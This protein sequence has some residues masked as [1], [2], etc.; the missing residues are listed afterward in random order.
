MG[1]IRDAARRL[2]QLAVPLRQ[3]VLPQLRLLREEKVQLEIYMAPYR[4]KV[5]RQTA[6]FFAVWLLTA[7][8][9]A[10]LGWALRW[11]S[12]IRVGVAFLTFLALAGVFESLWYLLLYKQWRFIVTD[13][14]IIIVTPDPK[15]RGFADAIYLK[16]GKIQVVDTN[17]SHNPWWGL[18]QAATGARDVVLSLA[19]YEFKPEG[20]EIKGGLLF[21]DVM[22]DDIGRLEE[23]VFG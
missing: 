22:P 14:R 7:L 11:S 8:L 21:P 5:A 18:F 13:K 12:Q 9:L 4:W 10:A 6:V 20:A 2:A 17:W 16:R 1:R 23:L 19:G 3:G 15:R